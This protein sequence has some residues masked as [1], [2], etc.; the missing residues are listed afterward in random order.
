MCRSNWAACAGKTGQR[1]QQKLGS[2]CSKNWAA[3]AAKTA[4]RVQ[5]KLG[6]VDG[7]KVVYVGD[8]N[9]IVHS[10]LRL[11]ARLPFHFVCCCPAGYE[12]DA[13]TVKLV[14]Q[15]GVG[16][17]EVSHEPM[18][19]VKVCALP[20]CEVRILCFVIIS[21]RCK[22]CALP[23]LRRRVPPPLARC[24]PCL[25]CQ[26]AS[27]RRWQGVCPACTGDLCAPPALSRCVFP[28]DEACMGV[29]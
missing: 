21:L 11:A 7:K 12:P 6:S 20:K 9:N 5:E 29:L 15:A 18:E 19:A 28:S 16:T 3:C 24:V 4:Q 2:V 23:V 13:E 17:V 22:K 8:G 25:H 1:V 26:G 10:W 27:F 14:E